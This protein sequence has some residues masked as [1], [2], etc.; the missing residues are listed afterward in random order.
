MSKTTLKDVEYYQKEIADAFDELECKV[1]E[2]TDELENSKTQSRDAQHAAHDIGF[3]E[4]YAQAEK[5]LEKKYKP[6]FVF[7]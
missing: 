5:D 4:G 7:R 6:K 2:L 3:D 1:K